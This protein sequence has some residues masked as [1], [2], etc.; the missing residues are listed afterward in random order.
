MAISSMASARPADLRFLAL[1]P[2]SANLNIRLAPGPEATTFPID[3]FLT[4]DQGHVSQGEIRNKNVDVRRMSF[5]R[6]L[7]TLELSVK[8]EDSDPNTVPSFPIVA[9]LDGIELS[10]IDSHPG[11]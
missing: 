8:A 3:F 4:D 5:P 7:S 2:I 6:G 9:E 1:R 10:D 11:K